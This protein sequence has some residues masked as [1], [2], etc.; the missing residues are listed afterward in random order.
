MTEANELSHAADHAASV[1]TLREHDRF[2]VPVSLSEDTSVALRQYYLGLSQT[3]TLSKPQSIEESDAIVSFVEQMQ[4]PLSDQLLSTLSAT[5]DEDTVGGVSVLRIKPK[6]CDNSLAP[7]VYVHGGGW[8]LGSARSTAGTPALIG[9]AT[10]REVIS[11]DYTLAPR[12][13]FETVTD[14]VLSVWNALIVDGRDT[15]TIGLLGDS[16]GGNIILSSTLKMRDQGVALPGA[17]W[18]LSPPTDLTFSGE[19]M[20]TVGTLDPALGVEQMPWLREAYVAEGDPRNPYASPLYGDFTQ[21]FP[22]TLIQGGT[23]ELLLSD[24]VRQYQAIRS[25]GHEAIL[26]L[27]EGMPH[28]FQVFLAATWEGRTAIDRAAAFFNSHLAI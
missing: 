16:A 2:Y 15:A 12:A 5:V 4:T 17:L 1:E 26:D 22:P 7:L 8:V 3:P 18:V 20:Y 11:I 27:Y 14:E 25:G 6:I 24:F 9:N 19:T 10:K 23:R 13:N 28:V 21:P